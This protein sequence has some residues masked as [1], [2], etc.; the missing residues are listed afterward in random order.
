MLER[1]RVWGLAVRDAFIILLPVTFIGVSVMVLQAVMS[2]LAPQRVPALFNPVWSATLNF[3]LLVAATHGIFAICLVVVVAIRLDRVLAALAPAAVDIPE[4]YVGLSALVNFMVFMLVRAPWSGA[5]FGHDGMLPAM[6]VGIASAEV[7]R[8]LIRLR[9]LSPVR[10]PADA[11]VLFYDAIRLT[12]PLML[13]SFAAFAMARLTLGLPMPGPHL[14]APLA[15]WA[16][17]HTFGAAFA[18]VVA[19]LLNQLFWFVGVHGSHVLNGYAND[20][21]LPSGVGFNERL[22]YRPLFDGFVLLGGSGATLGLLLA[23]LLAV[24]T[25]PQR[26]VSQLSLLP[27][28]FNINET[29]LYGLPL[30]LNPVYLLPFLLVPVILTLLTLA[31]VHLGVIGF[32]THYVPWTTPLFVSGWQLT[33]SWRGA[34]LQGLELLLATA[35]YLP[36]VR[37]AERRRQRQ[38]ARLFDEAARTILND[39]PGRVPAIRLPGQVGMIARGLWFDLLRDLDHGRLGLAYQPK[40]DRAG[41]LVGVEALLRWNHAR[42]GPISPLLA[43]VLAEDGGEI[44]RLGRWVLDRACACKA[45]WNACGFRELTM[46]VNVSPAQLTDLGLAAFLEQ[47]LRTH[48]LRAHEIELEITESTAIP[49]SPVVDE[50][51]RL[52]SRTGVRF[53]MDDFG[54]G[55]TSLLY[56]R[57]FQVHAIKIDGSLTREVL[58]NATNADI[59]RSIV[60]LGRARGMV[61][62]AEFVETLAQRDAL[63]HMGCDLFQGYLHS[64]PLAESR[65]LDYFARQTRGPDALAVDSIGLAQGSGLVP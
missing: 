31:A 21:F 6:V 58:S 29:L 57:R 11:D 36:F 37:L 44:H 62:V 65:C 23:V 52:L 18:S 16:Q 2:L 12:L 9:F 19:T 41:V 13:S 17:G 38:H 56:L 59:I 30:V 28:I 22:A 48:G 54:M 32:S 60:S 40:H 33:G 7:L 46:A 10:A 25:G 53:A 51:L 27:S 3:D 47:S 14:F 55:H 20:L 50:T 42:H 34:A 24:R 45:R 49:D 39:E 26:R 8:G 61:V 5:N 63:A 64:P 15:A 4:W 43:V 35:L 1:V